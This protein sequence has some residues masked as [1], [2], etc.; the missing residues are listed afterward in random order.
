MNENI[1]T[2]R[3]IRIWLSIF[4]ISLLLS[5]IT[6]FPI[7]TELTILVQFSNVLPSFLSE[8]INLIYDA[9]QDTNL[10]YPQLSYGSDWLAFGHIIITLFFIGP[11]IDPVKNVW[12]IQIGMIACLLVFPVAF[13]CGSIRSIPL[14]WQLIDCSF[15]II[16]LIPLLVI[17]K[18]VKSLEK[19]KS[20]N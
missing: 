4:M 11:L 13:I 18:K 5:G 16:G 1:Q 19:L 7:E 10:N 8:W 12:V 17:Y 2:L 20:N 14:F 3:S 15:G 6:A 9:I